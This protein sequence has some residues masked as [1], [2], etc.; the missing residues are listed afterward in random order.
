MSY[1]GRILMP[2]PL[3]SF[4]TWNRLGL[5]QRNL[6]ALLRSSDDFELYIADN[7][8]RDGTWEYL[9]ALQDPRILRKTRFDANRGP[10]YAGNYH[11]S[12]RKP[13]QYFITVDND[14]NIHNENWIGRFMETFRL[15]PEAGLLGAVSC[16]YARRNR[17]L[18][19]RR[20]KDGCC[21]LQSVNGFVEGCCQCIR[22]EVLGLIGYWSEECCVGDM[23]LCRRVRSYS[24]YTTGFIPSIEIDQLQQIPCHECGIKEKCHLPAVGTCFD[25]HKASYRNPQFR[26]RFQW[27]YQRLLDEL[28]SGRRPVYC[29]S[30]HDPESMKAAGY[31]R[32]SSEENFRYYIDNAN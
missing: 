1:E 7:N 5:T 22:P 18:L 23:E 25:I 13:G 28:E 9:E 4:V 15:F 27:K 6:K 21:Y 19:I 30:I 10:V 16:E 31:N 3:V 12:F 14:V 24:P 20:E 11:L 8:S 26:N 29:A 2:G 17:Q 32:H